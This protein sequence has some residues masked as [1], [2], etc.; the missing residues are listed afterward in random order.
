MEGGRGARRRPMTEKENITRL[1]RERGG[2][3]A[4]ITVLF[5]DLNACVERAC[6]D[7]FNYKKSEIECMMRKIEEKNIDLHDLYTDDRLEKEEALDLEYETSVND[8]IRDLESR[9]EERDAKRNFTLPI[10]DGSPANNEDLTDAQKLTHL[11]RLLSSHVRKHTDSF[12]QQPSSYEDAIE[13]LKNKYKQPNTRKATLANDLR[14]PR[15]SAAQ[16]A[17]GFSVASR[18]SLHP[19]EDGNARKEMCASILLSNIPSHLKENIIR[20]LNKDVLDCEQLL[21]DLHI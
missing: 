18:R 16:A 17:D 19:T 9:M 3:K 12:R 15:P 2:Y 11:K 6:K 20:E 1:R 21:E 14:P 13:E 5:K 10:F 7:S 8:K 4:R